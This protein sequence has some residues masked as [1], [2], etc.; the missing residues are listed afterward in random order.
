[1]GEKKNRFNPD[2][3]FIQTQSLKDVSSLPKIGKIVI[4]G[5]VRKTLFIGVKWI[6]LFRNKKLGCKLLRKQ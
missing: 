1:M 4:F 5:I 3:R 2:Y 6:E